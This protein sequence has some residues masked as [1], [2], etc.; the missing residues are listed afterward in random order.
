MHDADHGKIL[1]KGEFSGELPT[2][3]YTKISFMSEPFRLPDFF[4]PNAQ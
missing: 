2:I 3:L 1:Q 4:D